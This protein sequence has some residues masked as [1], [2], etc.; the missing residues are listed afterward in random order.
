MT[1]RTR[2]EFAEVEADWGEGLGAADALEET[3]GVPVQEYFVPP[4]RVPF[5]MQADGDRAQM[6]AG[7]LKVNENKHSTM[8]PMVAMY[9]RNGSLAPVPWE[10][11]HRMLAVRDAQGRQVFFRLPP[12]GPVAMESDPCPVCLEEGT[13]RRLKNQMELMRH[14]LK[15][16][17]EE[18]MMILTEEQRKRARGEWSS[19]LSSFTPVAD[20]SASEAARI[21]V[22][23]GTADEDTVDQLRAALA[24]QQGKLDKVTQLLEQM[25]GGADQGLKERVAAVRGDLEEGGVSESETAHTCG[26]KAPGAYGDKY[27]DAG[28]AAC[29]EIIQDRQRKAAARVAR[30]ARQQKKAQPAVAAGAA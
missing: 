19:L 14:I 11:R 9:R 25:V 6:A 28:C 17:G 27:L 2:L 3:L 21:A 15:L 18:S 29:L 5:G 8:R 12:N 24:L 16:H 13:S 26:F 30:P 22:R 23:E 4:S 7:G 10:K 20:I 1:T